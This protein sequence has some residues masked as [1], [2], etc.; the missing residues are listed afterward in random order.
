M[1]KVI[2]ISICDNYN[3]IGIKGKIPVKIPQ[4]IEYIKRT[5]KNNAVI[6]G[7]NSYL[8]ISKLIFTKNLYVLSSTPIEGFKTVSSIEEA[9]NDINKQP[10][11]N[12]IIVIG[13]KDTFESVYEK[14]LFDEFIKICIDADFGGDTSLDIN[15][16]FFELIKSTEVYYFSGFS[17]WYE[18]YNL[19]N[20]LK[21]P[22]RHLNSIE[23]NLPFANETE[24]S[25]I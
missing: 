13:G 9:I 15:F 19:K 22:Q 4:T 17:F 3:C 25:E 24:V 8:E 6:V 1:K 2:G 7:K 21:Y 23:I 11:K 20:R 18:R 10:E 16:D 12:E 5:V 14:N